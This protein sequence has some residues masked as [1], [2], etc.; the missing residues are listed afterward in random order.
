MFY[1]KFNLHLFLDNQDTGNSSLLLRDASWWLL[2]FSGLVAQA[3][4]AGR[5]WPSTLWRTMTFESWETLSN[6]T[7][8]RLMKCQWMVNN[9]CLDWLLVWCKE[10]W[11]RKTTTGLPWLVSV[12]CLEHFTTNK[13][14]QI[15]TRSLEP[16]D[17]ILL[18][19][20][21]I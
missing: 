11:W 13:P 14:I 9:S 1:S 17:L 6:T 4:L 15:P 20:Y 21:G 2:M 7:P 8:L 18:T 19:I 5:V 16:L 12:R 3:G 10:F